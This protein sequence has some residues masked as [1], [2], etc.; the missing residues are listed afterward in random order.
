M[1]IT[2]VRKPAKCPSCG[3]TPVASILYGLP[4]F[5]EK[6]EQAMEE[7][8]ISLGGCCQEMDAPTGGN[9]LAPP[10]KN[11]QFPRKTVVTH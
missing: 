11:Q 8:R 1:R 5:D 6:L 9:R 10:L 3:A 4:V 2:R 7:G